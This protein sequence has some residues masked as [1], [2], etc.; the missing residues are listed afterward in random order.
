MDPLDPKSGASLADTGNNPAAI[1]RLSELPPGAAIQGGLIKDA[2]G[3][4]VAIVVEPA[5]PSSWTGHEL[6]NAITMARGGQLTPSPPANALVMDVVS[7]LGR[8]KKPEEAGLRK[9]DVEDEEITAAEVGRVVLQTE[10]AVAVPPGYE[11]VVGTLHKVV[12]EYLPTLEDEMVLNMNDQIVLNHSY[13]DGWGRGTNLTTGT[14]GVFPV[15]CLSETALSD[16][17]LTESHLTDLENGE[18]AVTRKTT[19][20]SDK[21]P[22]RSSSKGKPLS[23]SM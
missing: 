15:M 3:T 7:T 16:K 6:S 21:L 1:K 8:E 23:D 22:K 17:M 5:E 10:S 13:E 11:K 20:S 12:Q 18:P 19:V 9:D 14:Q 4:T 2:S